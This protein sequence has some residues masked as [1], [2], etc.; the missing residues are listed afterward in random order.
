[1]VFALSDKGG[2]IHLRKGQ[3]EIAFGPS[4]QRR[5]GRLA[6]ACAKPQSKLAR[7]M[8][9]KGWSRIGWVSR[10]RS[11]SNFGRFLECWPELIRIY[12]KSM[13][14]LSGKPG[15][16]SAFRSKMGLSNQ[17]D[18]LQMVQDTSGNTVP[19]NPLLG[20]APGVPNVFAGMLER[21]HK[22]I[23]GQLEAGQKRRLSRLAAT[24]VEEFYELNRCAPRKI[25]DLIGFMKSDKL[26]F[27]RH[28]YRMFY[29]H[30]VL[31]TFVPEAHDLS[32]L[33]MGLT[34]FNLMISVQTDLDIS[35]VHQLVCAFYREVQA[36]TDASATERAAEMEHHTAAMSD[37]VKAKVR[38]KMKDKHLPLNIPKMRSLLTIAFV[39]LPLQGPSSLLGEINVE[40]KHITAKEILARHSNGQD[41]TNRS[42]LKRQM[43]LMAFDH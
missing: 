34:L 38:L 23:L 9:A 22:R 30:E 14:R 25:I 43:N 5:T 20:A 31:R 37:S 35:R 11:I 24:Y 6:V 2:Q 42:V 21:I 40:R 33:W 13:R 36:R 27:I 17:S 41:F 16:L 19:F 8:L 18:T 10:A 26:N 4:G 15:Y 12:Q 28:L 32:L 29:C 39:T 1:M 7:I 3:H